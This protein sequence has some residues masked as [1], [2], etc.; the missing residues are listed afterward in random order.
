MNPCRGLVT[1]ASRGIGY[2]A[3]EALASIG[4]N[5]II[6]SRSYERILKAS[7]TLSEH[8]NVRVEPL[9]CDLRVK[10]DIIKL[11]D[12][13]IEVYGGLDYVIVNYGN[14]SRE[15]IL[16]HESEWEDWIE[17][18]ALYLASTALIIKL[19]VEKNPVKATVILISSFTVAEPMPPLVV[20]DTVRSGLSR[21]VR[22]AAREYPDKI[23]PL[24][25][26]L[27]SFD[28]PGAR[29]TIEAL[30][31]K[32]GIDPG[33]LWKREV[34]S[35]SP[36]GRVGG[37]EELIDMIILLLKSPEYLNGSSILFDGSSSRIA[38]P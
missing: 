2:I 28:T 31:R 26:L 7:N 3:S 13:A 23:R 1:A 4:C 33:E 29:S 25:L 8:Y 17:A 35:L 18:S 37:R 22:V 16:L 9:E 12:K 6:C 14:P 19:L 27:G 34:E 36:L 10:D 15:P 20:A 32:R 30:A 5:L 21:L 11:I 24:L 38:L